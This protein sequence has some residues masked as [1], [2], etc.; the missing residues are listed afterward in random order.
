MERRTPAQVPHSGLSSNAS[1]KTVTLWPSGH[2]A[3]W[4]G[5]APPYYRVEG[6]H[7]SPRGIFFATPEAA[8]EFYE[9]RGVRVV[10]AGV[11]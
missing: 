10:I 1:E 3:R 7:V 8:T 11:A 5:G 9:P 6:E 2:R 4:V